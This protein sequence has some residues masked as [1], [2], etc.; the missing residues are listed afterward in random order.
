MTLTTDPTTLARDWNRV[1]AAFAASIMVDTPLSSLC[2]DLDGP[3]WPLTDPGE[4][5]ANYI[6]LDF[7]EVV[8]LLALKGQPATRVADLIQLLQGI[9]AFDDPFGAMVEQGAQQA[10]RDNPI[11]RNL[12]KLGIPE[13][14]P[15][16]LCTLE[17]GTQEFCRLEGLDTLGQF[18]VFTQGMARNVTMGGDFKAL[19]NALSHIDEQVLAR[20]LPYRPGT[21][22]LHLIEGVALAV[23]SA[24][25]DARE[26][27]T[28]A[29]VVRARVQGLVNHF[30]EQGAGLRERR[31]AGESWER[32]VAVL[33]DAAIEPVVAELLRPHVAPEEALRSRRSWWQRWLG[34]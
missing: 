13:N 3:A 17:P 28:E 25:P 19:L 30:A 7:E 23:R 26:S 6:D 1:R 8:E 21:P 16:A 33:N 15:I 2:Q 27:P 29:V 12:I 31:A 24:P 20:L 32:L 5:P 11:R 14:F 10:E 4:T 22:G 18:A 9:L 34:R